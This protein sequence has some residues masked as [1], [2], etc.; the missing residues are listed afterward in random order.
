MSRVFWGFARKVRC[1]EV[2]L[3]TNFCDL[4]ASDGT[5]DHAQ[6]TTSTSLSKFNVAR[7]FLIDSTIIIWLESIK[8]TT[9]CDALQEPP[10]NQVKRFYTSK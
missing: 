4:Q 7:K 5:F 10:N 6:R 8:M 9:R 2:I 1:D 3:R